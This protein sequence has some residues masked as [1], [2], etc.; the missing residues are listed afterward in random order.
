MTRFGSLIVTLAATSVFLVAP[1]GAGTV[2]YTDEGSFL[3]DLTAQGLNPIREDFE[4]AAWSSVRTTAAGTHTAQAV[5][6]QGVTWTALHAVTTGDQVGRSGWAVFDHV[7]ADPDGLSGSSST[8]LNAVGGWFVTNTPFTD[9]AILIDGVRADGATLRIDTQYR[10]IGVIS[11]SGF[12]RFEIRDLESSSLDPRH[13][14]ADDFVFGSAARA[15]VLTSGVVPTVASTH[16]LGGSNWHTELVIHNAA[17]SE[18]QVDLYFAPHGEALDPALPKRVVVGADNTLTLEDVV[19]G[20]LGTQGSGA[21]YWTVVAGDASKVLVSGYTYNQV[22]GGGR[23]GEE[24]PGVRWAEVAAPGTAEVA[25]AAAGRFRTNV[26]FATDQSCTR[27][28]V[29]VFDRTG[30]MRANRELAVAPTSSMQLNDLFGRVFPD[31]LPSPST[32]GLA[33]SLHRVEITGIDGRVVAYSSIID[34]NSNDAST[35]L[36][37]AASGAS[38]AWLP[39]VALLPGLGGSRWHS[40]LLLLNA[41]AGDDS[42]EAAVFG[43]GGATLGDGTRTVATP[44]GAAVALEDV[45][46]EPFGML[47]PALGSLRLRQGA[48]SRVLAW[49]R[50]YTLDSLLT[51]G[52]YGQTVAPVAI[53]DAVRTGDESRIPGVSQSQAVRSNLVLQNVRVGPSAKLL[54]SRVVVDVLLADGTLAATRSY[55]L[56]PGEYHQHNRFLVDYGLPQAVGA[57]LRVR[58]S[59]PLEPGSRGGVVALATVVDG[60]TLA[61]TNDSRT[62]PARVV[63][64]AAL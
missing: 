40:D 2:A 52:T 23:Y 7:G 21:L 56:A 36:A 5:T 20:L 35:M 46:F 6:S 10:F 14:F 61:G 38:E 39:T 58:L 63:V 45:L 25:P 47:A 60:N 31:L 55:S 33:D 12:T 17:S 13:W 3:A 16:G 34:N 41:G 1:A 62:I 22:D 64:R 26:G 8:V 29:R 28:M 32:V 54:P 15:Q 50:T 53:D 44:S 24:V 19:G 51:T 9:L 11:S 18:A 59:S 30:L 48:G 42:V 37:R 27:V 43:S 49:L 4:G 57:T